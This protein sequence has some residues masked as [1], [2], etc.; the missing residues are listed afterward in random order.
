MELSYHIYFW[1][2][3]Q[4]CLLEHT[5]SDQY[6]FALRSGYVYSKGKPYV[7]DGLNGHG[8]ADFRHG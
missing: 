1:S 8:I 6:N 4:V 3:E 2:L 7:V 5:Y